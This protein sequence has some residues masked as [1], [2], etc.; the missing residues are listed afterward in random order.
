MQIVDALQ[1]MPA[2]SHC[3]RGTLR[4]ALSG[5]QPLSVED[6]AP[7]VLRVREERC[8]DIMSGEEFPATATLELGE[9]VLEGCGQALE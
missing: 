2:F 5:E 8:Q 1:T 3:K 6:D 7:V 4:E 9:R